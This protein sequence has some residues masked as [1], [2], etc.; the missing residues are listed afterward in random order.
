MI[1]PQRQLPFVDI[2]FLFLVM[3]PFLFLDLK[4]SRWEGL[5]KAVADGAVKTG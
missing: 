3:V 4:F 5:I 2:F 1:A